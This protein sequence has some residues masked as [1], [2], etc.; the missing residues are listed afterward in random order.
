MFGKILIIILNVQLCAHQEQIE[1]KS[2]YAAMLRPFDKSLEKFKMR[3]NASIGEK[4]RTIQNAQLK[5]RNNVL[6]GK[7]LR[8]I[9]NAQQCAHRKRI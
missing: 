3:S 9:E 8:N 5:M 1:K 6:I 7:I 2:K 4:L